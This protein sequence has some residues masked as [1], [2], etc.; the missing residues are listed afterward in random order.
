M[1][2]LSITL[3][4][5][6]KYNFTKSCL[7]DLIK[8]PEDKYE[9]IVVDNGTDETQE[10]LKDNKR[11]IYHKNSTNLGFAGGSNISYKLSTAPNVM[12]INNDIR[13]KEL[14]SSWPEK[15]LDEIKKD[16]NCI[17]GPTGGFVDPKNGF[18]FVYES[19]NDGRKINYMSGWCLT[20]SKNTWNKLIT[21]NYV[22]PFSEEFGLAYFEDV[23]LS[24][25]AARKNIK[26]NLVNI[27]V[28]HFGKISSSQ[29]NTY[30]LYNN[31]RK[32]FLNKW[33]NNNDNRK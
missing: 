15:I 21:N 16:D 26:F 30:A 27:P 7:D 5:F 29:I 9:I 12:F 14:H 4:C 8:L 2:E 24:F 19:H 31:A 33:G 10:R 6:N 11:I 22:G 13:V 23:D 28:I 25:R 20:A 1:P 32:I 17:V 3:L 18:Q